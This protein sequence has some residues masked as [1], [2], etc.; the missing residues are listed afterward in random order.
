MT[1]KTPEESLTTWHRDGA[2][3]LDRFFTDDEIAAV[4]ADCDAIF[5]GRAKAAEAIDRKPGGGI[6]VFDPA[7]FRNQEQ[8]PFAASTAINLIGLHPRL[9]AYARAALGVE[10][11]RLYQCDAWAKYTGDADYDQPFHCDFKNHNQLH[12]LCHRRYR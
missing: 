5:A 7:Q 12:D 9:I 4:R 3:V 8:L 6:G 10:D 11:V 2:V 1:L